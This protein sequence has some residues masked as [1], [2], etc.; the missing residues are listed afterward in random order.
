M[1]DPMHYLPQRLMMLTMMPTYTMTATD[2]MRERA[3]TT[4]QM[5]AVAMT[6]QR[7]QTAI[8]PEQ[9]HGDGGHDARR[10]PYHTD[11]QRRYPIGSE[12]RKHQELNW[13]EQRKAELEG[14][15]AA[16]EVARAE[17]LHRQP[18]VHDEQFGCVKLIGGHGKN[19]D[20]HTK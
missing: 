5:P 18:R 11:S 16:R 12:G 2:T 20:R 7:L 6:L 14:A 8:V 3:I 13:P 15:H 4:M 17:K 10:V 1:H 9:A 19:G